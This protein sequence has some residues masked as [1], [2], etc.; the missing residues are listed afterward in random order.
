MIHNKID[1]PLSQKFKGCSFGQYRA[2]HGMRLLDGSLL[3]APHGITI[4]NAASLDAVNTGFKFIRS[5]TFFQTVKY[6]ADS[7]FCAPVKKKCKKQLFLCKDHGQQRFMG[8]P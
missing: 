1:I 8:I 2:E 3:S 5:H 7:T 6:S 4:I